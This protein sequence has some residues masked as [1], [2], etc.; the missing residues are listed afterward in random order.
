M[1]EMQNQT[2]D[3]IE[4]RKRLKEWFKAEPEIWQDIAE[5]FRNT[6]RNELSALKSRTCTSREWSAG[7]CCG[8]EYVLDLERWVRKSWIAPNQTNKGS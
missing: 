2:T 1:S 3:D 7:Y 8:I 4:R 5:E 6:H